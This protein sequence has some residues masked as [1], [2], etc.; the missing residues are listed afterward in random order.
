MRYELMRTTREFDTPV[1]RKGPADFCIA[2]LIY[3]ST[4]RATRRALLA[5]RLQWDAMRQML[6]AQ[7]HGVRSTD[8]AADLRIQLQ[9]CSSRS[10]NTHMLIA[11]VGISKAGMRIR[12][13]E[14]PKSRISRERRVP[15]V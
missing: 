5:E 3:R 8:P 2:N 4:L 10:R 1:G 14:R 7:V 13:F 9:K 15:G 12:P 6:H 11:D